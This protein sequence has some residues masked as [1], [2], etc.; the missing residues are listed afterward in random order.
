MDIIRDL[1]LMVISYVYIIFV[2]V[3]AD[4]AGKTFNL[5]GKTSRKILHI[6][7]GNIVLTIP[8]YSHP[9]F[10]LMV[11][12]PFIAITFL[13]SPYSPLPSVRNK[14]SMISDKT[15]IG[16]PLGLFFYSISFTLLTA[17]FFDW[18]FI[19]VAGIMPMAYGDGFAALIGERFG[20]WKYK[21]LAKKSVEGSISMLL[22]SFISVACSLLF[23]SLYS[24]I[25]LPSVFTLSLS[26][27][28]L[29]TFIEALSPL[30]IDDLLVPLTCAGLSCLL[31]K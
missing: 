18:P 1:I 22:F 6:L 29:A 5:S 12:I 24:P 7:T 3:F 23:Y 4:R 15:E 9:I 14:L 27:S 17:L 11:A 2:I 21:I 16:H 20:K 8:F 25:Q 10:P 26:V 28:L 13:A 19:I 30:G 31:V